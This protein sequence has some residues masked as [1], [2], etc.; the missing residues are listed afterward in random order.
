M[1]KRSD[2]KSVILTLAKDPAASR[3]ERVS[4]RI[5]EVCEMMG[6][7]H[8][9]L[10]FRHRL[11]GL[12]FVIRQPN[13][14]DRF[15]FCASPFPFV[16]SLPQFEAECVRIEQLGIRRGRRAHPPA[17]RQAGKEH[18]HSGCFQ[19]RLEACFIR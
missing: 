14:Q 18:P 4:L 5:I 7:A 1:Q 19:F 3:P 16:L 2:W 15:L 12:S 10:V 8:L 17:G 11:D 6:I 9:F 13:Q